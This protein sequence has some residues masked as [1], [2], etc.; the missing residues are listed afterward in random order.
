MHR[1]IEI[2]PPIRGII[3]I[4]VARF[5]DDKTIFYAIE[6]NKVIDRLETEKEDTMKTIG[7]AILLAGRHQI[8]AFGPD[9]VGVGAGVVDRLRELEKEGLLTRHLNEV[10]VA[11]ITLRQFNLVWGGEEAYRNEN[12]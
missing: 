4:D 1:V 12:I 9:E 11:I 6:N 2:R 8:N 7:R 5:G 10:D 3:S